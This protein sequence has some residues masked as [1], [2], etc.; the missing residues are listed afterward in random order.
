MND[1]ERMIFKQWKIAAINVRTLREDAKAYEVIKAIHEASLDIVGIQE[2]KRLGEGNV[3]I[4]VDNTDHNLI[5][6]GQ[7]TNR[8]YVWAL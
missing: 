2:V 6:K 7:E 4:T 5:W 1:R 8:Q 3:I